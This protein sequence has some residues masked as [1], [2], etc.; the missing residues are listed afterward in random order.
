MQ[1]DLAYYYEQLG[2][3]DSA[4]YYYKSFVAQR[5]SILS[6]NNVQAMAEARAS[7]EIGLAEA[8]TE[9][10][11]ARNTILQTRIALA[12]VGLVLLSLVVV[13]LILLFR[14]R[15]R[16]TVRRHSQQIDGLLQRQE[17]QT[18]EAI[19]TGQDRERKRLA[20]ELHDHFGSLL[21]TVRVNLAKLPIPEA[22]QHTAVLGMVDQACT[23]IRS[24]S[25]SLHVGLADQ[26]GLVSAIEAL[27]RTL[28]ASGRLTVATTL[29]LEPETLDAAQEIGLYRMVQE[30]VSNVLKHAQATQLSIVIT[31]FEEL[32]NLM[33]EDNGQGFDPEEVKARGGLGLQSLHER[34]AA[35]EGELSIDSRLGQGTIVN[36][37]V[38][39]KPQEEE[40]R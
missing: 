6:I 30:L 33:L 40:N 5:D 11:E 9:A 13:V 27:A 14:Y 18:L 29:S 7:Y 1:E 4:L 15:R 2:Q 10:S 16:R 36:V 37:D 21:A 31:G 25:H 17:S 24:L 28:N 35:L 20:T 38:P 23:D 8:E 3:T 32:V 22:A 26:F 12:A 34:V 39:I 19:I